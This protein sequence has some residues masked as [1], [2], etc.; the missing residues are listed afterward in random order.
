MDWIDLVCQQITGTV[1]G[2]DLEVLAVLVVDFAV[3]GDQ[4]LTAAH[5]TGHEH[6][7]DVGVPLRRA[8][9]VAA[10]VQVDTEIDPE[11]LES[12]CIAACR[13][14]G[15]VNDESCRVERPSRSSPRLGDTRRP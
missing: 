15:R 4:G 8:G 3:A 6:A 11:N 13:S 7:V 2:G 1:D 14:H 5:V 12:R 9:D 10:L